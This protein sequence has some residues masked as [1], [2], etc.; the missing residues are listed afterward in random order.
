MTMG[1]PRLL[2]HEVQR[3]ICDNIIGG[4]IPEEAAQMAGVARATFY[5]WKQL[6]QQEADRLAANPRAKPKAKAQIY[7]DFLDAIKKTELSFK[8]THIVRVQA[9][10]SEHW[11]AS[12]WI[13]ERR[14]PR[15]YGQRVIVAREVEREL[16]EALDIIGKVIGP[17]EFSAVLA[18][19]SAADRAAETA[20]A[21]PT[22]T[23]LPAA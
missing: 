23:E 20:S 4:L 1:R 16:E 22:G 21:D 2:T 15:E 11:Q 17:A 10:G 7:L 8:R 19:L 14:Y 12:A 5:L 18:A 6:G 13:L 9:A 3:A